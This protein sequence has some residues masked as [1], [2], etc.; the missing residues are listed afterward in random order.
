MMIL[1][2][3]LFLGF[4]FSYDDE[5]TLQWVLSEFV[6]AGATD[7]YHFYVAFPEEVT[8]KLVGAYAL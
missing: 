8:E 2:V 6:A 7:D 3:K 1:C 5:N 4:V